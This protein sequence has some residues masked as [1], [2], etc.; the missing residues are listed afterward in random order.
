MERCCPHSVF[1]GNILI[2]IPKGV[3][4][5]CSRHFLIHQVDNQDQT[6]QVKTWKLIPYKPMVSL[7]IKKKMDIDI[8]K[9]MTGR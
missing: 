6:S 7:T 4:R 8:P 2:D 5:V 1:P 9:D 3:F